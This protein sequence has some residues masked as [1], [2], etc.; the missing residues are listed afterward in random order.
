MPRLPAGTRQPAIDRQLVPIP[1]TPILTRPDDGRVRTV[2]DTGI[3][4]SVLMA[5]KR[6][7][8]DSAP[9]QIIEA[10]KAD[11]FILLIHANLLS[12]YD[13]KLNEEARNGRISSQDVG[14]LMNF[15]REK[16]EP[17]FPRLLVNVPVPT[18]KGY[19]DLLFDGINMSAN[20]IVTMDDKFRKKH[21][22]V[23][24]THGI[25]ILSPNDYLSKVLK[26]LPS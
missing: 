5:K 19:D 4:I 9:Y 3:F 22:D 15:M 11:K 23:A 20:Y 1:R 2:L 12:Q 14:A 8:L 25:D 16:E 7:H 6:G 17:Y 24:K 13:R 18:P 10:Y 21:K 26:R